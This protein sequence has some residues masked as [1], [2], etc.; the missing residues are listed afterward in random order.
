MSP[1]PQL[2]RGFDVLGAIVGEEKS[3][4]RLAGRRDRRIVD[5]PVRFHGSH[6]VRE[7]LVVKVVQNAVFPRDVVHVGFIAVGYENERITGFQTGQELF[8]DDQAGQENRGPCVVKLLE[9]HLE[10]SVLA[11]IAMVFLARNVAMLVRPNPVLVEEN[12]FEFLARH[13]SSG[14]EAIHPAFEVKV[15]EHF[16]EIKKQR[17]YSHCWIL[18]TTGLPRSLK[19]PILKRK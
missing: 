5:S 15:N 17:F 1:N 16:P 18:A 11:K 3:L 19:F 4:R 13:R 9:A 12:G 10:L 2:H 7:D 6:F 14:R 8:R